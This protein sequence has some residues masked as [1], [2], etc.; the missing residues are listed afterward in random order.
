MHIPL[1]AARQGR[2]DPDERP[3]S[4]IV[5]NYLKSLDLDLFVLFAFSGASVNLSKACQSTLGYG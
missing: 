2:D 5:S 4:I 1:T 3:S